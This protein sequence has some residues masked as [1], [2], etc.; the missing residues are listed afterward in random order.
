MSSEH[1]K[2]TKCLS[3]AQHGDLERSW[4][5]KSVHLRSYF[6]LGYRNIIS[7]FSIF[8]NR[9]PN[10]GSHTF[11]L[12]NWMIFFPPFKRHDH[13]RKI[14]VDDSAKAMPKRL[15]KIQFSIKFVMGG[16]VERYKEWLTGKNILLKFNFK[17]KWTMVPT[18]SSWTL[19]AKKIVYQ[20]QNQ[21]IHANCF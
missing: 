9:F 1:F 6:R 5:E 18:Q 16:V 19:F 17:L 12:S 10:P 4:K 7:D 14:T 20:N 3:L 11:R 15:P 13:L 2:H 8:G 21:P